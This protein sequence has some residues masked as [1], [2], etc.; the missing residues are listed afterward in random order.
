V[1]LVKQVIDCILNQGPGGGGAGAPGKDG[2]GIDFV[3]VD[4]GAP[5]SPATATLLEDTPIVGKRTLHLVIPAGK[6]GAP[7]G[8]GGLGL[9]DVDLKIV[10]CGSPPVGKI[11][12]AGGKRVLQL[13][14]PTNCGAKYTHICQINWKHARKM[15][16][17]DV[18]ELVVAFDGPI[19]G[20]DINLNS[21]IVQRGDVD[22][23]T[24]LTC[25]CQL[26]GEFEIQQLRTPCVLNGPLETPPN[27][28][29]LVRFKPRGPG[30][31]RGKTYRV[32]IK[33]DLIR[34]GDK[35]GVDANHLPPWVSEGR[36]TGDGIEGG[37]FESWFEIAG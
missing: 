2:K 32:I 19:N 33:G 7:G 12:V 30:F 13:E 15:S 14:I 27:K 16:V 28:P 11:V 26:S 18:R 29:N 24:G 3:T 37:T 9:D 8:P 36:V 25:W 22:G 35:K 4:T 23:L 21:F 34:D 6:V 1:Q 31:E 5:G 20:N 10:P 17:G